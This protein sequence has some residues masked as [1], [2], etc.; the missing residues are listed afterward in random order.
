MVWQSSLTLLLEKNI[1]NFDACWVILVSTSVTKEASNLYVKYKNFRVA[2]RV[3]NR[4]LLEPRTNHLNRT[5]LSRS[6]SELEGT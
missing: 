6:S 5:G 3:F 2:I 1:L 4:V